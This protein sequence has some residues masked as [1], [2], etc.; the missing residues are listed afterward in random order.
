MICPLL[1]PMDSLCKE[2]G[3]VSSVPYGAPVVEG[4]PVGEAGS[5]DSPFH[6]LLHLHQGQN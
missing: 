6:P 1:P 2:E 3:I 5:H 4:E